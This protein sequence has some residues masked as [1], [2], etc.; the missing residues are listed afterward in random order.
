MLSTYLRRFSF[1]Q[2]RLYK[3][4]L[5]EHFDGDYDKAL[6]E[7]SVLKRKY[8]LND[9]GARRLFRINPAV[10]VPNSPERTLRLR[11]ALRSRTKSSSSI[12]W[13][14][15]NPLQDSSTRFCSREGT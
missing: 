2:L 3:P 13:K 11:Q 15:R 9:Q 14:Q 4:H 5:E 1:S 8:S 10:F 6:A 7:V 12:S